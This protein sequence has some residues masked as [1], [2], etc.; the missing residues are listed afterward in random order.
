LSDECANREVTCISC[1]ETYKASQVEEHWGKD[2]AVKQDLTKGCLHVDYCNACKIKLPKAAREKHWEEECPFAVISCLDC[3]ADVLR[4]QMDYHVKQSETCRAIRHEK[5][6]KDLKKLIIEKE[7][8]AKELEEYKSEKEKLVKERDTIKAQCPMS[9]L[10]RDDPL[11]FSEIECASWGTAT[12]SIGQQV[13]VRHVL[14]S[15]YWINR[16]KNA[17]SNID[18]RYYASGVVVGKMPDMKSECVIRLRNTEPFYALISFQSDIAL[19]S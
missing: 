11:D 17:W 10:P 7:K 3:S 2:N 6:E 1:Q 13:I 18:G 16:D 19:R 15:T 9:I 4:K 8:L 14:N 5:M 12:P